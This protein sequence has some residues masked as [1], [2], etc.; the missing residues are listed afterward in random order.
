MELGGGIGQPKPPPKPDSTH[1]AIPGRVLSKVTEVF[2]N[3]SL[4]KDPAQ[5]RARLDKEARRELAY[6]LQSVDNYIDWGRA[7]SREQMLQQ[8]LTAIK[9]FLRTVKHNRL[10]GE[11]ARSEYDLVAS[12]NGYFPIGGRPDLIL[13]QNAG[14]TKENFVTILDGKNSKRKDCDPDQL[15]YYALCF[16]LKYGSLPD[17]LGWLWYRFPYGQPRADGTIEQG[18]QYLEFTQ[19]SL[20]EDLKDI[21][22]RSIAVRRRLE[23]EDF[24]ASP[25]PSYCKH[26]IYESVCGPRQEQRKTNAARRRK[27]KGQEED[28]FFG[29]VTF[30]MD[31]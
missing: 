24:E 28:D 31:D 14:G 21:A 3:Q 10:L 5:V 1:N 19:E 22:A 6:Q 18:V 8:L 4:Y 30:S 16:F 23:A 9:G 17:R 15:L 20:Q 11:F 2:Y 26:C 13:T 25:S 7:P 12:I 27:N 29:V